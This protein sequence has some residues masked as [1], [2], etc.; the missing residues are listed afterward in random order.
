VDAREYD[1]AAAMIR[2]LGIESIEL[3]TN[4][5]DKLDSLTELGIEVERR[6]PVLVEA[7][8]YSAGYLDVKRRQMQHEIPSAVTNA[9]PPVEPAAGATEAAAEGPRPAAPRRV[10]GD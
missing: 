1:V 8:R 4:N 10:S 6:I 3:L 5:P 7:T 9:P 2:A